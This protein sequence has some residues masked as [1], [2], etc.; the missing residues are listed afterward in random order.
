MWPQNAKQGKVQIICGENI[1]PPCNDV[2]QQRRKDMTDHTPIKV[3]IK[4][5]GSPN[6]LQSQ[7]PADCS[8]GRSLSG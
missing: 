4:P 3:H 1:D 6:L 7:F 2:D 8:K 5:E